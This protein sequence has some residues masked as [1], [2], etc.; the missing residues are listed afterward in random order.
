MI[1]LSLL[2]LCADDIARRP[3]YHRRCRQRPH[4]GHCRQ[5]HRRRDA[6][7]LG[8]VTVGSNSEPSFS[9]LSPPERTSLSWHRPHQTSFSKGSSHQ[10]T[11]TPT[12]TEPTTTWTSTD[13]GIQLRQRVSDTTIKLDLWERGGAH[14]RTTMTI[15]WL[16]RENQRQK[17]TTTQ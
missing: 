4:R 15:R 1:F 5:R 11:T 8:F 6:P 10:N 7:S 2:P 13:G 16:R 3:W 17:Y 12:K 9:P 14:V